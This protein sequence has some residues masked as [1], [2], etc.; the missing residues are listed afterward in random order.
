MDQVIVGCIVD[1]IDNPCFARTTLRTT[2]EVPQVQPQGAGLLVAC[3]DWTVCVRQVPISVGS[4]AS[5]LIFSPLLVGLSLAPSLAALVPVVSRDAHGLAPAG[6]NYHLL[7]V[8]LETTLFHLCYLYLSSKKVVEW[9]K[10]SQICGDIKELK[11][12]KLI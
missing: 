10:R 3:L 7:L 12:E 6:K 5:Q 8:L 4:R 9:G 11:I 1:N 2:G